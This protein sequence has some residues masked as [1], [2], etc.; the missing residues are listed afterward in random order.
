[1]IERLVCALFG[2]RY[3]VQRVLNRRTRKVGC[4]RCGRAWAMHDPTRSLLPW[5]SEFEA[6]YAPGGDLHN[7]DGIDSG[8]QR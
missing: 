2:H 6:M 7:L 3:V 5:D 8:V 1:M 4:T